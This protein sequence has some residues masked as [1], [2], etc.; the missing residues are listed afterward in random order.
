MKRRFVGKIAQKP[1]DNLPIE[2][3]NPQVTATLVRGD[4]ITELRC[5]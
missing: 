1:L 5:H 2:D 3:P 4:S